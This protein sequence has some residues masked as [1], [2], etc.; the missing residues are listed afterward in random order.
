MTGKKT[1][2]PWYALQVWSRQE[3][4]VAATLTA[5]GFTTFAPAYAATR[6]V[7]GRKRKV[8]LALFPGYLFCRMDPEQRL[9]VI[10]APGVITI[11][12]NRNQATPVGDE[13]VE[14]VQRAVD[15]KLKAEPF[16]LPRVGQ[17]VTL[18]AGPLAG[19]QGVLISHKGHSRLVISVE[20]LNRSMAVE[21]DEQW[22]TVSEPLASP[23]AR[24]SCASSL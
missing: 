9:H 19:V 7:S 1:A 23:R 17:R 14:A 20:L 8:E 3:S 2:H 11:L 24:A 22:A 4:A 16:G 10:T 15:S 18:E 12:G 13:E 5:K 21:I 6:I